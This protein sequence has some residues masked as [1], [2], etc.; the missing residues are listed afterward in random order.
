MQ[1]WLAI[2]AVIGK[3]YCHNVCHDDTFASVMKKEKKHT[4]TH[5]QSLQS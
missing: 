2:I 1:C 4:H 5:T 3:W